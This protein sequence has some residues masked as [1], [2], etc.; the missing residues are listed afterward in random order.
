MADHGQS[1]SPRVRLAGR[2]RPYGP[3]SQA[4]RNLKVMPPR[5][6]TRVGWIWVLIGALILAGVLCAVLRERPPV[7]SQDS[8]PSP[9]IPPIAASA[10]SSPAGE[11]QPAEAVGPPASTTRPN[12]LQVAQFSPTSRTFN[13]PDTPIEVVF[14]RPVNPATVASAFHVTPPREGTLGFPAPDR[15]VFRPHQM[16]ERGTT[17]LVTLDEGIADTTGLDHLDR[18][19]WEFS[20]VGGYYYT[21]DVQ[22]VVSASC[23]PCHRAGA[24]AASIRLD[25]LQDIRRFAQPGD[26]ERSRFLTVLT[27]PNHQ[28]KLDPLIQAKLYIVHDWIQLNQAAD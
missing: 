2:E 4:P 15:L 5:T 8:G 25:N 24:P 13:Y 7:A 28:G 6:P 18:T 26:P 20:T 16:W 14:S 17:Y 22:P 12:L 1:V 3:R 19:S 21:R 9:R 10:P 27:D 11:A 23:T